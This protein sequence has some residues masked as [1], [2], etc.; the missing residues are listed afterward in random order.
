MFVI[1]NESSWVRFEEL[2]RKQDMEELTMA[3]VMEITNILKKLIIPA[4]YSM[5]R[6]SISF[7]DL[8][9]DLLSTMKYAIENDLPFI[10]P[11]KP[12]FYLTLGAGEVSNAS[13]DEQ[14]NKIRPL[15]S[16]FAGRTPSKHLRNGLLDICLV[17]DLND[18]RY[19]MSVVYAATR[20]WRRT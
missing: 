5:Q 7:F 4:S 11:S 17:T 18:L 2:Y 15:L 20:F 9:Y 3:D 12:E 1:D 13:L 14:V 16:Y 19:V 8:Y 6:M 10:P